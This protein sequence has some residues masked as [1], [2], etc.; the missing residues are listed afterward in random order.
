MPNWLSRRVLVIA[1]L[2]SICTAALAYYNLS[3]G[4][5][6]PTVTDSGPK[7]SVVVTVQD[8][9]A[10]TRITREVVTT[11][12][13]PLQYAHPDAAQSLDEVVGLIA[14]VDLVRDEQVL[15]T[16]LAG[17]AVPNRRLAY[18]IPEG[19]RAITIP[20]NEI[21]GVGGYP[22]VGDRVDILLTQGQNPAI[23]KTMLQNIEILAA[24]S[25]T[26]TQEDGQQMIVPS[27]TLS[28]TPEQAQIITLAEA[29]AAIRLI[30]RSPVDEEW[31]SVSPTTQL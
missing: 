11:R 2:L 5:Y 14:T 22:T 16:R 19:K 20:I 30:L 27:F 25:M 4:G 9:S 7:E 26:R 8:V 23:T 21:K 12:S 24:G 15:T 28:V 1:L 31:V 29:T 6:G 18:Q 10:N 13:I 17:E 3:S